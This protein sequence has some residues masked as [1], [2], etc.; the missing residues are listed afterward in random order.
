MVQSSVVI[1]HYC[2]SVVFSD[3]LL[4]IF[5]SPVVIFDGSVVFFP[6]HFSCVLWE[7]FCLTTCEVDC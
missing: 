5:D 1:I 7:E 3:S 6:S 2:G 4:V